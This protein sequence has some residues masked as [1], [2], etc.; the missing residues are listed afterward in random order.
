MPQ[1]IDLEAYQMTEKLLLLRHLKSVANS[2]ETRY[3]A[4]RDNCPEN[5]KCPKDSSLSG[6]DFLLY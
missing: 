1:E 6:K 3:L 4:A 5:L 2:F